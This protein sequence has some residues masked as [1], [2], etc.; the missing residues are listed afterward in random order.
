M[1]PGFSDWPAAD[2]PVFV[3]MMFG[4]TPGGNGTHIGAS[5][6]VVAAGIGPSQG[7]RVTFA[8]ILRYGLPLAAAQ[9][10]VSALYVLILF[11]WVR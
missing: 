4:T 1:A 9:I 2:L 6:N 3:A 5:A 8:R 11:R 7:E 10:A